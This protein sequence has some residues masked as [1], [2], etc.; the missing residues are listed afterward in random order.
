MD[1]L[2]INLKGKS[3]RIVMKNQILDKVFNYS[4]YG[5]FIISTY[6]IRLMREYCPVRRMCLGKGRITKGKS[7]D[8]R[9]EAEQD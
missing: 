9:E 3:T 7:N 2:P 1:S 8:M 6:F 5:L 4:D